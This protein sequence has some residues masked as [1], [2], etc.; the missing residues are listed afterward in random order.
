[1]EQ[2][3]HLKL[4]YILP[5]QAQK[6]V[7]HN[8]ALRML[9][10]IVQMAVIA[11]D[12]THP[13]PE[14]AEGDRYIVPVNAGGDWIDHINE[15]AAFADGSWYYFK[16]EAGWLCYVKNK[17]GMLVFNGDSWQIFGNAPDL[18]EVAMLGINASADTTNRLTVSSSATLFNHIGGGH[19][20]KINKNN[21]TDTASLLFQS[22][23]TG[24]AEMGL[25]GSK[26]FSVKV[27]DDNGQWREAMR[28]DRSNGNIMIGAM[29][30]STRL[31]IDGPI[32]PG[33]ATVTGLPSAASHGAGSIIFVSNAAGGAQHAYSDGTQ[34][35]SLRTGAVIT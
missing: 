15:L 20:V 30:P 1:M 5:S 28:I 10:A 33:S 12:Y 13:D 18:D 2:T 16:P 14:A 22:S 26:D 25:A 23:W 32:R 27:G 6:H 9:D 24:H 21:T 11:D 7:T 8:E 4:P 31:H 35:R 17:D 29:H 19:Q 3:N 34:W